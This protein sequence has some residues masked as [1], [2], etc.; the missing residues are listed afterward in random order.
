M[1]AVAAAGHDWTATMPGEAVEADVQMVSKGGV[2]KEGAL[3]AENSALFQGFDGVEIVFRGDR[4]KQNGPS[5]NGAGRKQEFHIRLGIPNAQIS[6]DRHLILII[7][8]RGFS[9][10]EFRG[11]P[12][13][14]EKT[15]KKGAG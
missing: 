5:E 3:V 6:Q 10:F 9:F 1:T 13:K 4:R 7:I 15:E 12:R 14:R 2:E 11:S 8:L